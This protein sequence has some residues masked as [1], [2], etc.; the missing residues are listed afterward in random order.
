M[1][2]QLE[3]LASE[4]GG[5]VELRY[6]RKE[7]RRFEVEKGRVENAAIQQR[8]GVSVRVL[9]GGTWGF[10]ATSDPSQAAVAKAIDT[11]RA[12]AR[13]SASYRRN[14][15]PALPPGQPAKGK[16]EE[17]GYSE[18]YDKPLE[19]KID[20]VLLAEREARESSSQVE[21]ARAAYAEIFEEKSIVTSDGA[22]AD[23]RIVRPEFRVNA[24]ANGVHRAT[25]SEMIGV[26]GGWDCI[27]GRSPQ[28]MAEKASRSAVELAAAEYAP[29]GRFKVI[30][31]PSIVGLLVHEAIGHTVEADF[32]LAGS[33]AADR[34][35]QRVGSELVTLCDSGHSEHLPNAG[36]TIPV[37]DEGMLTQ[38]TV[39]IE[40][41]LLRSYLHNRET[42]A[43]FGVAP[44]GN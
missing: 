21:T 20:V 23:V 43:H 13:A 27:F 22:S 3:R 14:K 24:V 34:I 18:L 31:A 4:A 35:G 12:A 30:L 9:E 33:A 25:Y 2:D 26:T 40:N 32:V 29:G 41:G 42:A 38:R 39:I 7:T 44:T 19:A 1:R 6:H 17:P 15:I 8:A 11:A 28:E 16:F 36:G 37:D 5:F 10:A